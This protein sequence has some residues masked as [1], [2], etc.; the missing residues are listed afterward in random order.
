MNHLLGNGIFA[1]FVLGANLAILPQLFAKSPEGEA[2]RR[3]VIASVKNHEVR[4]FR[5]RLEDLAPR[6]GFEPRLP[7][8]L[9]VPY[10]KAFVVKQTNVWRHSLSGGGSRRRRIVHYSESAQPFRDTALRPLE[11]HLAM[12]RYRLD[13]IEPADPSSRTA[14]L[15]SGRATSAKRQG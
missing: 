9:P 6:N 2:L 11:A 13:D 14:G 7:A 1:L 8:D 10:L 5:I 15:D 12:S 3:R 4:R